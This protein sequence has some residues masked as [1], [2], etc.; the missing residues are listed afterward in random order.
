MFSA[1]GETRRRGGFPTGRNM[2][3][4]VGEVARVYKV[5]GGEEMRRRTKKWETR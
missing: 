3:F 1:V 2:K 4:L 5:S